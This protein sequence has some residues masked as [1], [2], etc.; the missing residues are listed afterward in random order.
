MRRHD[1]TKLNKKFKKDTANPESGGESEQIEYIN[2]AKPDEDVAR[3][4]QVLIC[5]KEYNENETFAEYF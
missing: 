1:K 5:Y 2:I 4:E 3:N